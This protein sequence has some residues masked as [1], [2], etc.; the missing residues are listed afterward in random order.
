MNREQA[1]EYIRSHAE[2][3]L[4]RDRSGKGFICPLCSSGTGSNGTGMTTKDNVHFT[5]W[6][7][8]E[9]KHADIIDIIGLEYGI[10]PSDYESKFKKAYEMFDIEGHSQVKNVQNTHNTQEVQSYIK[11]CASRAE[12]TDYFVTRGISNSIVAQYQLGYDPH[13]T[14]STGGNVWKAAIIP[15][16]EETVVARNTNPTADKQNKV[17]KIGS[18]LIFNK[19]A[20]WSGEP[21]FIVE[22][23]FDTLSLLEVG[24][25]ACGL[26]STSNVDQLIRTLKEV[27]PEG[28]LILSLDNDD[29]GARATIKLRRE[30]ESQKIRFIEFNISGDYNDPNEALMK[31]RN[32]FEKRVEDA[33]LDAKDIERQEIEAERKDYNKNSV[34]NHLSD[35]V[36]GIA[37]SVNT[38]YIP[39]GFKGLDD[40]L[41]GGFYEG[42]YIIG[43]IS[44]LGKTSFTLQVVDQ[45]AQQGSDVLIYSLEMARTEL[46]AKSV[47]RHTFQ[48]SKSKIEA[49][50]TRGITTGKRYL[51]YSHGEKQLISDSIKAYSEYAH[52][53][54]IVEGMGDVGTQQIREAVE[55]HIRITGKKPT[56]VIDYLQLLAPAD[57]RS[58][59]KQ[60]TDKAVMDLKR[61]T[62]DFKVPILAISSF[63]RQSYSAPVSMESFKESGSIEFSSDVLIG[64]QLKGVGGKDFDVDEA[65]KRDPRQVELKILKNRNGATGGKLS[66]DYF[67]LF[68]YFH[69]GGAI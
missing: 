9:I 42:L 32:I 65:K 2:E 16:S 62:R 20:L 37:E 13:F 54:F 34:V 67:P 24:A 28:I 63:N 26:G 64:L 3:Y 43:A 30:L 18:S 41:D 69:E 29:E 1:K 22:G 4:E 21:C 25:N 27:P 46:I 40:I 10:D 8:G 68:N 57:P 39:T 6:S 38:P 14:R 11:A 66:Y 50:T 23:E 58:S 15:T 52:N 59:D 12:E 17:R 31:N 49:K 47:S 5:C 51:H 19:K 45:I 53:I 33:I 36:N 61:I 7:C 55:R 35:F 48:I 60:N 56:V 44:S